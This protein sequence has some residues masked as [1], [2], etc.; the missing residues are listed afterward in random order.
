MTN[1]ITE[2]KIRE[3]LEL[4]KRGEPLNISLAV[5]NGEFKKAYFE[6]QPKFRNCIE[7]GKSFKVTLNKKGFCSVKCRKANK[8][9]KIKFFP[10]RLSCVIC[11]KSFK[12]KFH[13]QS[14]CSKKCNKDKIA[15]QRHQ[16]YLFKKSQSKQKE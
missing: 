10:Q 14:T 15:E 6:R 5:L 12:Q 3:N 11:E 9:K 2:E 13:N 8:L 16:Y 1:Q 4:V 7:C